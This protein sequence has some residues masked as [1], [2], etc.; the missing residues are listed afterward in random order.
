QCCQEDGCTT[1]ASYGKDG[2]TKREFCSQ[3][4][5]PGMINLVSKRCRHPGC[6]KQPSFGKDGSKKA[7]FCSQHAKSGMID[8]V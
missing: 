2:S 6:I 8:L 1:G 3:H 7:E 4:A 5:K